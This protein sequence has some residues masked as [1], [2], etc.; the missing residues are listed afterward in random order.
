MIIFRNTSTDPYYNLA[1]EESLLE[2]C[3]QDWFMLWRNRPAIIVGRNQI[4]VEEINGEFVRRRDIAVVRRLSGG[5][6]VYHDLGNVNFTFVAHDHQ[7]SFDFAGFAEPVLAVLRKLEV[8]AEYAGRNDLVIEG[9]KFSGNAQYVQGKKVLHHGTLL[10][11]SDLSILQ[12]A[13]KVQ[14][15]KYESKGIKSVASRTTN[16]S[17]YLSKAWTVDEFSKMVLEHVQAVFPDTS[18]HDIS[19]SVHKAASNLVI[20][21]YGTW[22][23]NYGKSSPYNLKNSRRFR[24]GTVECRMFVEQGIIRNVKIYGDFFGIRDI[25]ELEIALVGVR[26]NHADVY[27][28]LLKFD[29]SQY[30]AGIERDEI[31]QVLGG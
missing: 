18:V 16:I 12:E 23:W 10:F 13:L 2:S 26:H 1:L 6:A 5:G 27:D 25:K 19:P 3:Q 8:C 14:P 4:T 24:G 17:Q 9:R 29:L 7:N 30:I 22:E 15:E 31:T 28:A 21:K 20:N 11:D